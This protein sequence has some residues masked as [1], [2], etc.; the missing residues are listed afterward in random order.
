MLNLTLRPLKECY[1]AGSLP[2][3]T[4]TITNQ[5]ERTIKFSSYM[6]VYRLKSALVA[7][8][9]EPGR[10]FELQPFHPGQWDSVDGSSLVEL[11]PGESYSVTL[12]LSKEDVFGFVRRDSQ[13]PVF[14]PS[15]ILPGFPQGTWQFQTTLVPRVALYR[16]SDGV[17]DYNYQIRDLREIHS[18]Q[19]LFADW[20]DGD[21]FV[22]FE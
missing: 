6:L 9:S 14:T 21:T 19:E 13:P 17:H 3:F 22:R 2:D 15:D 1:P 20:V 11:P 4:L 5:G 16:G 10:G 18:D 7:A 8:P 12:E